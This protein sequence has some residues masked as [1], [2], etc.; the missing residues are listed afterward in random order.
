FGRQDGQ[1]GV[2]HS[3]GHFGVGMKR[4]LF[5]MAEKFSV[6]S[7]TSEDAFE[8]NL[9]VDEWKQDEL[10]WNFELQNVERLEHP[11]NTRVVGTVV[12][13]AALRPEISEQLEDNLF[14]AAVR[15]RIRLAHTQAIQNGLLITFNDEV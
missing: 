6:K 12:Q 7:V 14:I 5:K 8:L 4:T 1:A 3:V 10:H 9:D 11:D 2:Q 15:E 13:V